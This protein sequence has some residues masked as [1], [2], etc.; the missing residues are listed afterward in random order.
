[1]RSHT[2][3]HHFLPSGTLFGA[4]LALML[5]MPIT[6]VA[7][8]TQPAVRPTLDLDWRASVAAAPEEAAEQSE[9]VRLR[10]LGQREVGFG[11]GLVVGGVLA[12]AIVAIDVATFYSSLY[13][14]D[15]PC[16]T[17]DTFWLYPEHTGGVVAAVLGGLSIAGGTALLIG[18][19]VRLKKLTDAPRP[20]AQA[21]RHWGFQWGAATPPPRA[22]TLGVVVR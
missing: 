17:Y 15:G 12:E 2:R 10:M 6:A 16:P 8:D 4:V 22:R 3:V 11:I 5:V 14:F 7:A 1:M 9:A 13:C 21:S 20:A 18:G 19:A